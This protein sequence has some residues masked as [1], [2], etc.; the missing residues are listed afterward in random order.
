MLT[1]GRCPAYVFVEQ[2]GRHHEPHCHVLWPEGK[3]SIELNTVKLLA[4]DSVPT[5]G[6]EFLRIHELEL[7][8]AWRRL[9]GDTE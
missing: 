2:G 1:Y 4:G 6:R 7:T 5:A 8:A 9:I 3:W